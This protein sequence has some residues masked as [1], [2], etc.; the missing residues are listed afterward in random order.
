MIISAQ[1]LT[2]YAISPVFVGIFLMQNRL[3]LDKNSFKLKYGA[4]YP[5]IKTDKATY[6]LN[7]VIYTIRRL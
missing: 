3:L 7:T 2:F 4:L 5:H 1:L 6:I